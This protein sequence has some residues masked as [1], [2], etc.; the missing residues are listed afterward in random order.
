MTKSVKA[1]ESLVKHPSDAQT[2]ILDFSE[3]LNGRTI[4][5]VDSISATS[6]LTVGSEAVVSSEQIDDN[7]GEPIN[8]NEAVQ[9]AA[10][11]GTA[12]SSYDVT[13]TV[14]LSD[15]STLAGIQT[16]EVKTT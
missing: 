12:G 9:Y 5:S 11:G 1:T 13:I 15:A 10:S 14:T 2:Y 7:T 6:G 8:A 16:F 4:S 3:A